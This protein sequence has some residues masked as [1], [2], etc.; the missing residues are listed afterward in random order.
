MQDARKVEGFKGEGRAVACCLVVLAVAVGC[1][2]EPAQSSSVAAVKRIEGGS[3]VTGVGVE[4]DVPK[5]WKPNPTGTVIYL[6]PTGA[7]A[8]GV[9]EEAYA[10]LGW[11]RVKRP[12]EAGALPAVQATLDQIQPGLAIQGDGAAERMG[13]LDGRAWRFTGTTGDGRAAEARVWAAEGP[14]SMVGLVAVGFPGAIARRDAEIRSILASMRKGAPAAPS[15][16]GHPELAG[17]WAYVSNVYAQDGGSASNSVLTLCA[18]GTY[19]WNAESSSSNPFGQTGMQEH[20]TGRWSATDA[21]LTLTSDGGGSR[22]FQLEKQN[23]PKNAQDPMI[24]LDGQAYVTTTSR[25]PW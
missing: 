14:Q 18:D 17:S 20:E 10:F 25:A 21:T 3:T 22:T 11:P 4:F 15:G 1:G 9:I 24:V 8:N 23:H 5:S 2:K 6:V 12:T 13:E 19:V 16:G 7:N